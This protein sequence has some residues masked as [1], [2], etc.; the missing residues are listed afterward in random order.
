M[1]SSWSS[2]LIAGQLSDVSPG[3]PRGLASGSGSGWRLISSR[4]A[5]VI[6]SQRRS[7]SNC[8][9]ALSS[10][11][12]LASSRLGSTRARWFVIA[13]SS[14]YSKVRWV[15]IRRYGSAVPEISAS[16]SLRKNASRSMLRRSPLSEPVL[17]GRL[18]RGCDGIDALFRSGILLDRLLSDKTALFQ[19]RQGRVNLGG[20]HIPI[21]FAAGHSL[22]RRPQII[23]MTRA[24]R[25]QGQDSV[26]DGQ[27]APRIEF[28]VLIFRKSPDENIYT[29]SY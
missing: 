21:L 1:V 14:R 9:A 10:S 8:M 13:W 17:Q 18:A 23:S 3:R 20:L 27:A 4:R 19:A 22:E 16:I 15:L 5:S 25:Q 6:S 2:D 24:L 11:R 12:S 26:A 28:A 7:A 29:T